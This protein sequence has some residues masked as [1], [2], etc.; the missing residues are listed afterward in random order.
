[1][2]GVQHDEII[3]IEGHVTNTSFIAREPFASCPP[4]SCYS[5]RAG[6]EHSGRGFMAL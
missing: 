6:M 4:M 2:F 1:M 5:R 3:A